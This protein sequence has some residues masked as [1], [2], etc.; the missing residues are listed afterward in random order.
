MAAFLVH[1]VA[2]LTRA[3]ATDSGVSPNFFMIRSFNEEIYFDWSDERGIHQRAG[4][5]RRLIAG[6]E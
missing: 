3:N 2:R 6:Y 4:A 5:G 1:G